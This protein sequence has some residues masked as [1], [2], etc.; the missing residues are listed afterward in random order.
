M[1]VAAYRVAMCQSGGSIINIGSLLSTFGGEK[2]APYS[3]AKGGLVQMT[4]SMA[5]AWARENVRV[6]AILPGWIETDLTRSARETVL[7]LNEK[8]LCDTPFGRWGRPEE[9]S[10]AAVMLAGAAS[11]FTTGATIRIDG[12][13][14]IAI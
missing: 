1:S 12:G 2:F 4:R 10:G 3:M 14:G 9:I 6:N 5:V 11:G 7:G 8:V 13:F